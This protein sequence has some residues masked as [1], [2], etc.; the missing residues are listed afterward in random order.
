MTSYYEI[1]FRLVLSALIGGVIGLEREYGNRPA[2]LRT[3]MLVTTASALIMLISVEGFNDLANP[4]DPGRIAAQVV[5]GIGFLGAGTI[6]RTGYSVKGLT[7]AASLW[8]CGGIGLALG[9]G[10]YIGGL[11][12]AGII[13][14]SLSRLNLVEHK[15]HIKDRKV[16]RVKCIERPGIIGDL[17]TLMGQNQVLVKE[18]IFGDK[19]DESLESSAEE[20]IVEIKFYLVIPKHFDESTFSAMVS[21]IKGVRSVKWM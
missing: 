7:T 20:D 14:L 9:R 15:I 18:I 11:T 16:L 21:N 12:A 10:F 17:G 6:L 5:S 19:I 8:A 1:V 13:F 2:G 4:G 3:H